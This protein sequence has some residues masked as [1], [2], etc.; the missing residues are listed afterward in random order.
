MNHQTLMEH[1]WQPW[2]D[3]WRL[4]GLQTK[5]KTVSLKA[6]GTQTLRRSHT[7]SRCC[8]QKIACFKKQ[9]GKCGHPLWEF[10]SVW[11]IRF[12]AIRV[13]KEFK[14][15]ERF[16]YSD[17]KPGYVTPNLEMHVDAADFAVIKEVYLHSVT[18]SYFLLLDFWLSHF[19]SATTDASLTFWLFSTVRFRAFL[20]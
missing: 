19:Y 3:Y 8:T 12:G 4:C 16:V 18:N 7:E 6:V 17:L 13:P 5:E 10:H 15:T 20:W 1:I 14:C 2:T 9:K 11:S